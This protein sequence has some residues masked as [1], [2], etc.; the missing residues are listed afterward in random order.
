MK[1]DP[2]VDTLI[3]NVIKRVCKDKGQSQDTANR[4]IAWFR[5]ISIGNETLIPNEATKS[6][7]EKIRRTINPGIQKT[8]EN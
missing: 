1:E 5:E 6:T 2:N 8:D 3:E 7:V 4:I